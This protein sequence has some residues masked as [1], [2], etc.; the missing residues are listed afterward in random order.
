MH[1]GKKY[2]FLEE[3]FLGEYVKVFHQNSQQPTYGWLKEINPDEIVLERNRKLEIIKRKFI[4]SIAQSKPK[5][6]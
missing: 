2:K 4:I 6:R 3:S 1:T 5:G